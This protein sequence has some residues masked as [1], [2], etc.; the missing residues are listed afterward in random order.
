MSEKLKSSI[1]FIG[2]GL[3]NLIHSFLHIIQFVQSILLV[4]SSI[5]EHDHNGF[6]DKILHNPIFAVLWGIIGIFTLLIGVKDFKHHN[7]CKKR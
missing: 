6:I 4:H 7:K 1:I 2:I 5:N 3:F